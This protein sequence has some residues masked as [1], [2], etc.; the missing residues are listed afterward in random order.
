VDTAI[1]VSSAPAPAPPAPAGAAPASLLPWDRFVGAVAAGTGALLPI[2]IS[3]ATASQTFAVK[4]ALLLVL[5]GAG[6]VPLVRLAWASRYQWQARAAIGFVAAGAVSAALSPSKLVGF[7][8][9]YLWGE[10]EVFLLA[11]AAAWA[12]GVSLN[13]R[14]RQWLVVGLLVGSTAN[15]VAAVL[16][17][18]LSLNTQQADLSGF[19]LF[20]GTQAD[21]MLGNPIYLEA[22]LLGGLALLLGRLCRSSGRRALLLGCLV[23]L[24]AAA[25]E[26]S[27][28]R[29]GVLVL[30]ALAGYAVY[31]YRRRA[32]AYVAA[33]AV[34]FVT[35]FLAGAGV[36]LSQRVASSTAATTYS[37]RLHVVY[38]G[39]VAT[40]LHRPLLGFG[41]GEMRNA[42]ELYE[43]R[44]LATA[45]GPGRFFTDLHEV[46]AN[47]FVMTGL[48]GFALFAVWFLGS[49]WRVRGALAGFAAAVFAVELVEPMNVGVTPLAFLALGAALAASRG[50]AWE[51]VPARGARLGLPGS[52]ARAFAIVL[53]CLALLPA[54]VLVAGDYF[55]HRAQ[56]TFSLSDARHADTLLPIWPQSADEVANVYAYESVVDHPA[57]QADLLLSRQW[58]AT[59]A[60]RDPSDVGLWVE[61]AA[62]DLQLGDLRQAQ[63]DAQRA[64]AD[65]RYSTAAL[66]AVGTTDGAAGDWAGAIAAYR[67]V[68]V[69]NPGS[70]TLELGLRKALAH[71]RAFFSAGGD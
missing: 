5:T 63:A 67:E 59:A 17:I 54:G 7:F 47:F 70:Q 41:P 2:A 9:L 15:A 58:G 33:V 8:G 48:I 4:Y 53:G 28:E 64:L 46:F 43:S 49:A 21:G 61:L 27:S 19:G 24:H 62:A 44:S 18:A 6:L 23:A 13:A 56:Q 37:L 52:R 66:T 36:S 65:D 50:E 71:D 55:L 40:L 69:V 11:L 31:A 38:N 42:Q 29:Y 45:I 57:S 3:A 10:G 32:V 16:Q 22:V 20:G 30:I 26:C 60:S 34:G 12:I 39:V 1:S 35:T 25:I 14:T 68:L 51:A